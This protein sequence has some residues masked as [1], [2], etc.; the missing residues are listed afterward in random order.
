[1]TEWEINA[2]DQATYRGIFESCNPS[3]GLVSGDIAKVIPVKA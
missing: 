1:M 3:N 2:N